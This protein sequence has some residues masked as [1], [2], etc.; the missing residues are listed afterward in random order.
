[1]VVGTYGEDDVA[2]V[3]FVFDGGEVA[4]GVLH[5][6]LTKPFF[7]GCECVCHGLVHFVLC[8][9]LFVL[10]WCVVGKCLFVFGVGGVVV[11]VIIMVFLGIWRLWFLMCLGWLG[12]VW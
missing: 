12:G 1:M 10:W 7:C 9:L 3:G 11:L 2:F 8:C 4:P 6:C 5:Y